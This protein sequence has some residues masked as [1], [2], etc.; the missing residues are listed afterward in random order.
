MHMAETL[1]AAALARWRNDPCGF[2]QECLVNPETGKPFVLL[3][4]E[5]EFLKHALT[6]DADGRLKH[7]EWIFGAIKKTG[8]SGFAALLVITVLLLFG[9][10]HAE[11]Y[12]AANDLEQAQSRVFETCRRIV[13]ASPLLRQATKVTAD[14]ITFPATGATIT[15]LASDY[16]SAAGGHPTIAVFDELW[17]YGSERAARLYDEL[18]PVPT[19][20]ISCRLVVTHAG[21]EG[22]SNLLY[23]LYQ[24][25]LQ[26][27]LVGTDLRA[28]DGMLMFWSHVPIA[29]WQTESWLASMRRTLRPSQYLRMMEN[30]FVTSES[31]FVDMS[32]WDACVQ[33]ALT[34]T[35]ERIPV[36]VGVDAS[37]KRDSTAIVAVAFDAKTQCVRLVQHRVF[38]PAPDD[39]INFEATVEATL[40]EWRKRYLVRKVLFDPFQMV[41]V[42]QRLAKAHIQIEEFPQTVPNLTAC[43]QC[44]F[45]AIQS[46]TL[47]LY[48][49]VGMRTSASRAVIVES[50]RGW[51]LDKLKQQHKIDV[52]VALSM[53]CLAAVRGQSE[54][55]YD[56]WSCF[57]DEETDSAA[58]DQQYRNEFAA[59]IFAFSGGM[60]WPR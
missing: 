49:D 43:T 58:R 52:V 47:A 9:G 1:T 34:P 38:T 2:I 33:P 48:P 30:R 44:L 35:G 18:V 41:S 42:A 29:P 56:L 27:P 36:W 14:R 15:C 21:F 16:A 7:S 19:R 17:G 23:Q 40:L 13:E 26:Q 8:K 22:E 32:A 10:R 11:A 50:S 5:R 28:G 59:R 12:V 37:V 46:R 51:R 55:A 6:I 54:P 57:P 45:D 39:P 20:K 3:D 25:G 4:A 31:N 60:C 24:R 53:A